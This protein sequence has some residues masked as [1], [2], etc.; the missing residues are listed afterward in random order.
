MLFACIPIVVQGNGDNKTDHKVPEEW[1]RC[2]HR[3]MLWYISDQY[4]REQY[5][6]MSDEEQ[7][8]G[9]I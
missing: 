9:Q 8:E 5:E 4:I 7:K 6:A 1:W 2:K 3:W